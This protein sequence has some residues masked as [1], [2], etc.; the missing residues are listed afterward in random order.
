MLK[1][2]NS[3]APLSVDEAAAARGAAERILTSIATAASRAVRLAFNVDKL[4]P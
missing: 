2:R 1:L 4:S 3:L